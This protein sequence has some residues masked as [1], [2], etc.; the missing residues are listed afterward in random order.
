MVMAH[1]LDYTRDYI[2]QALT[3]NHLDF[4]DEKQANGTFEALMG[5]FTAHQVGGTGGAQLAWQ[6]IKRMRPELVEYEKAPLLIHAD[7]LK[8]LSSPTYLLTSYPI[9]ASAFNIL[10]GKS[11]SG[12]SFVALDIAGR[13][14]ADATV[15]YIAGEGLNGYA[16]RWEAW[17]SFHQIHHA[18]LYF[19]REALQVMDELQLLNFI[20]MIEQHQPTLVIIDTLARSAVGMD[21]NS[22]RDMGSFVAAVDRLRIA[23]NAA[24]LVVHHT[25]KSGDMRG[26]TALYG[27]ADS[28][29]AQ[30]MNDGLVTLYNSPD[31]GGKNKFGESAEPKFYRIMAHSANGFEGAV[32]VPS[33]KIMTNPALTQ[34]LTTYQ[35]QILE[36][37]EGLDDG[38]TAKSIADATG[39]SRST[40]YSNLKKLT[41]ANFVKLDNERYTITE[42]GCSAFFG[43]EDDGYEDDE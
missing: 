32:L 35:K 41:K 25:G 14:A 18:E 6:T 23:L 4:P 10:S 5:L 33:E 3:K 34:K 9:Y 22:A 40:V 29:I 11:G 26:S 15:V 24:V 28:V 21:E 42:A 31:F 20:Q 27:A 19:Y 37:L 39:F 8:N 43:G 2:K 17:K 7:E 13:V 36:A 38:L 1:S 12:K 30:A 16:A